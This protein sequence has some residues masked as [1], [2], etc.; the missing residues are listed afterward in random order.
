M[1]QRLWRRLGLDRVVSLELNSLGSSDD[2]ARYRAAL[3]AI[4]AVTDMRLQITTEA[5][6]IFD[7]AAAAQT[8]HQ[9]GR[10]AYRAER[11]TTRQ[12]SNRKRQGRRRVPLPSPT[13]TGP[14]GRGF[15]PW[16]GQGRG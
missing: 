1:T 4:G 8:G 14:P 12:K 15:E 7:V 5:A 9:R 2:R 16:P 13:R 3:D 6:G 11:G 10:P